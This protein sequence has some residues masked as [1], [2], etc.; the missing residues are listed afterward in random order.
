MI[1][2]FAP[3]KRIC[4]IGAGP[5]GMSALYHWKLLVGDTVDIKCYEKQSTWGGMW[6]YSWRTGKNNIII[7]TGVAVY[8]TVHLLITPVKK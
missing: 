1:F 4:I 7:L 8:R 6:N 2:T 3:R 5:G